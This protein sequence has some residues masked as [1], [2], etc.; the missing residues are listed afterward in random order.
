MLSENCCTLML[1]AACAAAA[2]SAAAASAAASAVL[3]LLAAP[4]GD[5]G[6]D[7]G[8]GTGITCVSGTLID[9]AQQQP[10]RHSY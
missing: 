8:I 10:R 7:I 9:H 5:N 4:L 6:I 3:H 2:A 1:D